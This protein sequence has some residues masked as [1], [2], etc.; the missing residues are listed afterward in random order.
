M[1][2]RPLTLSVS[3]TLVWTGKIF[4]SGHISWLSTACSIRRFKLYQCLYLPVA[5]PARHEILAVLNSPLFSGFVAVFPVFRLTAEPQCV[6]HHFTSPVHSSAPIATVTW[7][8][9]RC[10]SWA[11]SVWLCNSSCKQLLSF[12]PH[13]AFVSHLLFKLSPV[14]TEQFL[15]WSRLSYPVMG[16]VL[17]FPVISL[18]PGYFLHWTLRTDQ[19]RGDTGQLVQVHGGFTLTVF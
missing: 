10:Y 3:A 17:L 14:V 12:S 16:S 8:H 18:W 4:Y 7:S 2:S 19:W 1:P 5:L 15:R 6:S 11:T 9:F 13:A